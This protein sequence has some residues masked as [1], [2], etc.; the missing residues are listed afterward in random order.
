MQALIFILIKE[1]MLNPLSTIM[2]VQTNELLLYWQLFGFFKNNF[3]SLIGMLGCL[4]GPFSIRAKLVIISSGNGSS[5]N[6]AEHSEDCRYEVY[7]SIYYHIKNSL[8]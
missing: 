2:L 4:I 3:E 6:R 8:F 5:K 1:N 7:S